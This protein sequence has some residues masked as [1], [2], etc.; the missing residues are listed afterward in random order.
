[1][2]IAMIFLGIGFTFFPQLI[3]ATDAIG[4][5]NYT[6]ATLTFMQTANYTGLT[7]FYP[8][9][10]LLVL[11]ALMADAV[12]AGFLGIKVWQGTMAS[13]ANVGGFLLIGLSVLFASIGLRFYPTLLDGVAAALWNGGSYISATTYASFVNLILIVPMLVL[14]A[15]V[16]AVA[17]PGL[18]GVRKMAG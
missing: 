13:R 16:I 2:G 12:L 6:G 5:Y 4:S 18:I 3:T 1:M 8:L 15:F 11:I 10:P 17:L 7:T 14:L 9:V